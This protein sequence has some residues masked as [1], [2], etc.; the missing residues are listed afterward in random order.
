MGY[1]AG[2]QGLVPPITWQCAPQVTAVVDRA[3]PEAL[4]VD[5]G[6]GGRRV[7]PWVKTVD[8]SQYPGTDYVADISATPFAAD[9]VDLVISTGVLEHVED[10]NAMLAEMAR[11]VKPGGLIHIEIPFLQFYHDDPVDNRRLTLPGLEKFVARYGFETVHSGVHIGPTVTML[12]TNAQ[13]LSLL[14]EGPTLVHKVLSN[15]VFILYRALVFPLRYLD[16]WLAKKPR[17][18]HLAFGVFVTARK[19]G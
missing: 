2:L 17:A 7:R 14:F 3:G 1:D 4:V 15:G 19:R 6:A 16:A 13:W 8:F 18:H 11:I 10:E 9:S 12:H 5:L